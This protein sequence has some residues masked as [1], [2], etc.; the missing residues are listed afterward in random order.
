MRQVLPAKRVWRSIGQALDR[1]ATEPVRGR[2]GTF[3]AHHWKTK[4]AGNCSNPL[5][6]EQ[7]G[8]VVTPRNPGLTGVPKSVHQVDMTGRGAVMHEI[9]VPC[10]QCENC[11]RR[12]AAHWRQRAQA[13]YRNAVRTWFVTL[14]LS[15]EQHSLVANACRVEASRNGEDFDAFD[16]ETKFSA[17]HHAISREITL[18]LKRVRKN[19]GA[20]IRFCCVAEAHKTGLPHY[21]MLVHEV[22]SP[23]VTWKQLSENWRVGFMTAKLVTDSKA[24]SYVTKYLAKSSLARVRASLDYGNTSVRHS[25]NQNVETSDPTTSTLVR[26]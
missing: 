22:G 18:Y 13:E 21:H 3:Q 12:R 20:Q 2:K 5:V 10:R 9:E 7:T 14:T 15:P 11:L 4:Y 17:R 24:A 25:S 8:R 26:D 6:V 1:N 23:G 16:P 19:A